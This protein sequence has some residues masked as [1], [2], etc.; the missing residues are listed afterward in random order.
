MRSGDE[1]L[2]WRSGIGSAAA[3]RAGLVHRADPEQTAR[4]GARRA[5]TA[6][7]VAPPSRLRSTPRL[8]LFQVLFVVVAATTTKPAR[9]VVPRLPVAVT[10]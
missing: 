9:T 10:L 7:A 2:R 5:S 3:S 8:R 4:S 6:A 1:G